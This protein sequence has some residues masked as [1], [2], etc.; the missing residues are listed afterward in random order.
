M[1]EDPDDTA[2]TEHEAHVIIS[3]C[4]HCDGTGMVV[5]FRKWSVAEVC[6]DCGGTGIGA[7]TE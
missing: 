2:A 3:D 4:V 1:T 6:E 5:S 7:V